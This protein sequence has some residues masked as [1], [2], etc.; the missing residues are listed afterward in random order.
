MVCVP[1]LPVEPSILGF[2]RMEWLY[3]RCLLPSFGGQTNSSGAGLERSC[4][5]A[6]KQ[7]WAGAGWAGQTGLSPA[8]HSRPPPQ[9]RWAQVT[10]TQTCSVSIR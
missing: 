5:G 1:H 4:S 10:F 3:S 7:L 8:R 9:R 2:T 6:G